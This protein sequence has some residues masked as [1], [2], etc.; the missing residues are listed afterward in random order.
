M[1]STFTFSSKA[2]NCLSTWVTDLQKRCVIVW[3]MNAFYLELYWRTRWQL[4]IAQHF[5][6]P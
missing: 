3:N 4:F 1:R 2:C 5:I 6:S